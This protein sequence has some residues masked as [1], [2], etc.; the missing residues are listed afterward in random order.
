MSRVDESVLVGEEGRNTRQVLCVRCKSKILPPHL[1]TYE[2]C[3][4]ELESMTKETAGTKEVLTQFYRVEDMYDFDNMGFTNTVQN[5]K[6]LSCSD[7]EV[8]PLGY[9]NLT[10]KKS[11]VALAR[12]AHDG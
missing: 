8:G 4:F 5:I 3:E 9:H 12:V 6:Y 11:Y 7:C 2:E 10:T 1:G